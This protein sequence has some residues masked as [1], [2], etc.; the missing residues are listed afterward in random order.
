MSSAET[1][2]LL[3]DRMNGIFTPLEIS[4]EQF[5]K[6]YDTSEIGPHIEKDY[7]G[8]SYLS[9]PFAYRYLK[10]HFLPCTWPLKKRPWEKWCL[11]VL[12]PTISAPI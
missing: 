9:W 5:R 2:A 6:A 10:E 3:A 11:V 12:A 7:K 8:L 4:S 1:Q